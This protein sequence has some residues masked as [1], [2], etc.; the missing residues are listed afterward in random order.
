MK[1]KTVTIAAL[2]GVAVAGWGPIVSAEG[3][4]PIAGTQPSQR[5]QGAPVVTTVNRTPEWYRYALMGVS[6]PYPKSLSF[7]ENQGNWYTPFNRPGMHGRYD[8][9]GWYNR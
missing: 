6:R 5:P 3:E 8:I 1:A 9:R 2:V 7:L 4:Y